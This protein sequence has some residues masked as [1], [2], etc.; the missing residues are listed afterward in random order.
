M[1]SGRGVPERVL[2]CRETKE[3]TTDTKQVA[4]RLDALKQRAAR[5]YGARARA[6]LCAERRAPSGARP[7]VVRT[8]PQRP[9]RARPLITRRRRHGLQGGCQRLHRGIK[10]TPT[11]FDIQLCEVQRAASAPA[12]HGQAGAAARCV[13]ARTRSCVAAPNNLRLDEERKFMHTS[14]VTVMRAAAIFRHATE[15]TDVRQ[16]LRNGTNARRGAIDRDALLQPG[17]MSS[18]ANSA[19]PQRWP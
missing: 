18:R 15:R 9:V 2:D 4:Q 8:R 19:A 10:D 16:A 6:G 1:S 14:F 13:R 7:A 11:R 5:L 3:V 12:W 17:R